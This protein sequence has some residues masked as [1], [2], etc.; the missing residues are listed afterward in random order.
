M[1]NRPNKGNQ[2]N[3]LLLSGNDK[4]LRLEISLPGINKENIL[5]EIRANKLHLRAKRS[6]PPNARLIHKE[7][8]KLEYNH[9]Y[10]LNGNIDSDKIEAQLEQGLLTLILPRKNTDRKLNIS[11]AY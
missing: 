5:L 1:T 10:Q 3:P 11:S 7:L 4:N 8:L 6:P 2:S 9:S